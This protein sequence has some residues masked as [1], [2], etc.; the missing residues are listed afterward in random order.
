VN[1]S[2][3][4]IAA[5]TK[6]HFNDAGRLIGEYRDYLTQENL[7]ECAAGDFAAEIR[8]P[9][10]FFP[11]GGGGIYLAYAGGDPAGM[12]ALKEQS[13]GIGEARRMFVRQR[14]RGLGLGRMLVSF[15]L[16]DA[17]RVKFH[18]LRLDTFRRLPYAHKVYTGLGFREIPPYNDLPP[19]K[20]IFLER[21]LAD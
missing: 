20:V 14:F 19:D 3:R 1:V 12:L 17:G 15:M 16:R 4:V 9:A 10:L 13:P 6:A 21:A 2:S 8:D 11:S 5:E 7:M 18:T